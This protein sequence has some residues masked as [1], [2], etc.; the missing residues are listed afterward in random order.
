MNKVHQKTREL[1]ANLPDQDIPALRHLL[2]CDDCAIEQ[3]QQHVTV[4]LFGRR[5]NAVTKAVLDFARRL[6]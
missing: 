5:R 2:A 6:G 4:T 3:T 1:I